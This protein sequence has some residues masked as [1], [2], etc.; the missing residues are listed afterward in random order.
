M[1][2]PTLDRRQFLGSAAAASA[3]FALHD[4]PASARQAG[5]AEPTEP[6]RPRLLSLELQCGLPLADCSSS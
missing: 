6:G 1:P 2:G 4:L 3:F 5:G